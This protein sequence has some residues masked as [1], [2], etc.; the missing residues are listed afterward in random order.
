M[1]KPQSIATMH[2]IPDDIGPAPIEPGFIVSA[3]T[4]S[5]CP[6]VNRR[7]RAAPVMTSSR[8]NV[9]DTGVVPGLCPG[10]PAK[11]VS[12]KNGEQ[13][14]SSLVPESQAIAE[15]AHCVYMVV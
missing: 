9:S 6:V 4:A 13:F 7:R 11:A 2:H 3:T 8:E 10:P 1:P 5:S 14:T 15:I 12:G